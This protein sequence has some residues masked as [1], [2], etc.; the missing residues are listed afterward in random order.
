MTTDEA[1]VVEPVVI[2]L[3][4]DETRPCKEEGCTS[5]VPL[6]AHVARVY[7]DTHMRG[8]GG[9]VSRGRTRVAKNNEKPP[10]LAL[11]IGKAA[12]TSK[13]D[14]K[15]AQTAEGATAFM[16]VIATGIAMSGDET[17]ASAIGGGAKAWGEAVGELS[18]Y[19]PW[20]STFFAPAGGDNQLGAWLGF[21][22]T[23]GAILLPVLAHH[24]MLPES[25]GVKLAGMA[26]A[27]GDAGNAAA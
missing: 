15:A 13:G 24:G 12:K 4:L 25:V 8:A 26:V 20:L 10:R 27:A 18:K 19:Q 23:T 2:D 17:C 7:C 14:A 21:A 11:E 6:N 5:F 1:P 22:M 9:K 3:G 16:T